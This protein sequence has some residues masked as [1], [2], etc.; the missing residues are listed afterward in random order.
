MEDISDRPSN[1]SKRS[2]EYDDVDEDD[3]IDNFHIILNAAKIR[4]PEPTTIGS[5]H[6]GL[7]R[8]PWLKKLLTDVET[9]L[10]SDMKM[11]LLFTLQNVNCFL[12][13]TN[14][15]NNVNNHALFCQLWKPIWDLL[16]ISCSSVLS[17]TTDPSVD[18]AVLVVPDHLWYCINT[19]ATPVKVDDLFSF[20]SLRCPTESSLCSKL[21]TILIKHTQQVIEAKLSLF[22][23]V[24][25]VMHLILT[26]HGVI[27]S[28]WYF[29][30]EEIAAFFGG[31]LLYRAG[32]PFSLNQVVA[33]LTRSSM[34]QLCVDNVDHFVLTLQE[35]ILVKWINLHLPTLTAHEIEI[36]RRKSSCSDDRSS[37]VP[38]L[39]QFQSLPGTYDIAQQQLAMKD[40]FE[41]MNSNLV[42][43]ERL[44]QAIDETFKYLQNYLPMQSCSYPTTLITVNNAQLLH[45]KVLNARS[46]F[47]QP[48]EPASTLLPPD[49]FY[50]PY[51]QHTLSFGGSMPPIQA[52]P[53]A[54]CSP[55][56]TIESMGTFLLDQ[57]DQ[58]I[59]AYDW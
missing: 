57:C 41:I 13:E 58:E 40:I 50:A 52:P 56:T 23:S 51:S 16:N 2:R 21:Q 14:T 43:Q 5:T 26:T 46:S 32:L 49:P 54:H 11:N 44:L 48:S 12:G 55:S 30:I 9:Y 7:I 8:L 10:P 42:Y 19:V 37:M 6:N 4:Q 53:R 38:P 35:E 18:L 29:T 25:Y 28:A 31:I 27:T 15:G 20:Q 1:G 47:L 3:Y 22:Q 24:A 39:E 36:S 45:S 59:N 17:T 33:C 34:V